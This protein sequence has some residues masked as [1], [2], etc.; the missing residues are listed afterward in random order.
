MNMTKQLFDRR[1]ITLSDVRKNYQDDAILGLPYD[2][3]VDEDIRNMWYLLLSDWW[4]PVRMIV[5]ELNLEI[6]SGHMFLTKH[7]ML[8]KVVTWPRIT[9]EWYDNRRSWLLGNFRNILHNGEEYVSNVLPLKE[10]VYIN[11]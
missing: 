5:D 10:F 8:K 11:K 6:L 7:S 2:Y 9:S 4:F 1:W 3:W